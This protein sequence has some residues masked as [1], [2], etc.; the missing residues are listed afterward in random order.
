MTTLTFSSTLAAPFQKNPIYQMKQ[1]PFSRLLPKKTLPSILRYIFPQLFPSIWWYKVTS[2]S[3]LN[4]VIITDDSASILSTVNTFLS[5]LETN[6]Q[7]VKEKLQTKLQKKIDDNNLSLLK[8]INEKFSTFQTYLMIS[9]KEVVAGKANRKTSSILKSY[10]FIILT[11]IFYLILCLILTQASTTI[12]KYTLHSTKGIIS[13]SSKSIPRSRLPN[14]IST[15][16]YEHQSDNTNSKIYWY[17]FT[18]SK[19]LDPCWNF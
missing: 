18:N 14:L 17:H 4:D 16:T 12:T 2:S 3:S 5:M 19:S 7:K 6:N 13:S 8:N 10:T 15:T 1:K 11:L 9:V